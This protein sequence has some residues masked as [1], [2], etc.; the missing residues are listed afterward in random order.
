MLALP[1][2][3]GMGGLT[4]VSKDELN[5]LIGMGTYIDIYCTSDSLVYFLGGLNMHLY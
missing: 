2:P 3:M 1:P 4:V 5:Q